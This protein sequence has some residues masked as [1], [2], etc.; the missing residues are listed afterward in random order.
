M[1]CLLAC[2]P[3]KS[4]YKRGIFFG[5]S[6]KLH[7]TALH[8]LSFLQIPAATSASPLGLNRKGKSPIFD[9]TPQWTPQFNCA[10]LAR[11]TRLLAVAILDPSRYIHPKAD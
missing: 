8:F 1:S 5:G 4:P 3:C 10:Y 2:L 6:S 11:L 9:S 7:I